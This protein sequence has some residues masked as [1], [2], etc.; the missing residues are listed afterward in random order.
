MEAL[1]NTVVIDLFLNSQLVISWRFPI[2][3][4]VTYKQTISRFFRLY[5]NRVIIA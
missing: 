1:Y 3:Q 2:S 4:A 5:L